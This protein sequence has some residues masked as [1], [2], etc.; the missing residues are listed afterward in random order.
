MKYEPFAIERLQD[1]IGLAFKMQQESDFQT[2]PFDIE[3]IAN[4]VLRL[5]I[6]NPRGFGVIAYTDDGKPSGMLTGSI[7]DYVF[8]K[9]SI[10]SDFAWFVLPEHRGSRTALK[11]LNMFKSWACENGATELYMGI[12]TNVSK[13]RTGQLLE[14]VG[15]DHVG[16]NYRVRLNG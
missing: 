12:T 9:G 4:S 7:T 6:D 3:Q 16:G 13:D 15:F 14:R 10:A 1:I 5:V 2:V 11:M 8:S